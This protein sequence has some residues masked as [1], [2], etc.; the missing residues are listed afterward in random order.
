MLV[1]FPHACSVPDC[2]PPSPPLS[3]NRQVIQSLCPWLTRYIAAAVVLTRRR[4]VLH[5]LL[6]LLR[7]VSYRDPV[8]DRL[9]VCAWCLL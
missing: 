5:S 3:S 7:E 9:R 1:V 4:Y 6:A 2:P 8:R